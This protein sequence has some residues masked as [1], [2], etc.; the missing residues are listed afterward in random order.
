MCEGGF[1]RD[2]TGSARDL[3]DTGKCG[4]LKSASVSLPPTF[5]ENWRCLRAEQDQI[6]VNLGSTFS[7]LPKQIK[8]FGLM[9]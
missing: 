6:F 2:L 9:L 5:D 7:Y 1:V 3:L 8:S 4:R